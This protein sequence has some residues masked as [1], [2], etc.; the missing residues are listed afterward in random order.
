MTHKNLI[1]GDPTKL[2]DRISKSLKPSPVSKSNIASEV[3]Y[4][5]VEEW[6]NS[7]RDFI[8]TQ[9]NKK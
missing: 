6:A 2:P 5:T 7:L 9:Q 1:E 4:S 8:K 3:I